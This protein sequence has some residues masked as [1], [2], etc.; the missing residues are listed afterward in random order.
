[1][2]ERFWRAEVI[3]DLHRRLWFNVL[4]MRIDLFPISI[5]LCTRIWNR[6]RI[7][8]VYTSTLKEKQTK[9]T[10]DSKRWQEVDLFVFVHCLSSIVRFFLLKISV[11]DKKMKIDYSF[12]TTTLT[13][14]DET[15]TQWWKTHHKTIRQTG[16]I[17][18]QEKR[19]R[20][21]EERRQ[22]QTNKTGKK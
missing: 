8:R 21:S 20:E 11:I 14:R 19:K 18:M 2:K 3:I 22:K 13:R 6:T 10:M 7:V 5:L 17:E 1:M 4:V 16:W 15:H 12:F 9:I